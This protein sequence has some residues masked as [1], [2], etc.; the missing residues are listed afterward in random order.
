MCKLGRAPQCLHDVLGEAST[1]E[2]QQSRRSQRS[3]ALLSPLI[4][5]GKRVRAARSLPETRD[6]AT[7]ELATLPP[8]FTRLDGPE[9][10]PVWLEARL[11]ARR[12]AIARHRTR[13]SVARHTWVA[14][15]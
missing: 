2:R 14:Q 1:D 6:Y 7:R 10:Y 13:D 11:S 4:R 9:P 8:K 12:A 15:L 3:E 5:D